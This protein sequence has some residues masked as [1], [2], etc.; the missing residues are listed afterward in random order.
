VTGNEHGR[1]MRGAP[2]DSEI[3]YRILN[4]DGNAYRLLM[5]RYKNHALKIIKRRVPASEV[6]DVAQEV[7]VKAYQSLSGFDPESHF[8]KWLSTITVR[9]CHDYWRRYYRTR[10][11]PMSTLTEKHQKW[12]KGVMT[13]KADTSAEKRLHQAEAGE[14]LNWALSQLS[15]KDRSVMELVYLEGKTGREA[16]EL[17]GWSQANVKVR[18]FR[19]RKKLRNMLSSIMEI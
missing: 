9:T 15:P 10:E 19:I 1:R 7:F 2:Q 18:T 6:E 13:S 17:L 4:G 3:V 8:Q 5:D 16:A 11:I 14:I 12:L